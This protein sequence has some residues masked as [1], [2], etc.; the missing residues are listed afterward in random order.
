MDHSTFVKKY[1]ANALSVSVDRNKAGFLYEKSGL[2]P[3]SARSKQ[4]MIRTGAF[5]G[6][7]VGVALLFFAPWWLALAVLLS[8]FVMFPVAHKTAARGVLEASLQN[9]QV[10]QM[11]VDNQVLKV[12][13][14]A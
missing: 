1:R 9:A 3:Q 12:Q 7:L 8:G 14:L 2:M 10:Y 13:N 11:A 6:L 4:A 5:G